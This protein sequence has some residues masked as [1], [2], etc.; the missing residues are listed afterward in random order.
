MHSSPNIKKEVLAAGALQPVIGL[1][2]YCH[3]LLSFYVCDFEFYVKCCKWKVIASFFNVS[4]AFHILI[5]KAIPF[6]F[7]QFYCVVYLWLFFLG[8]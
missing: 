4:L 7:I 6:V 2:R 1:L 3:F 5:T 8:K